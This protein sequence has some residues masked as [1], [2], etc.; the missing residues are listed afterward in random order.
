MSSSTLCRFIRAS[1]P[2]FYIKTMARK[3]GEQSVQL[4]CHCKV[5]ENFSNELWARCI[6]CFPNLIEEVRCNAK[7]ADVNM[8]RSNVDDIWRMVG[9]LKRKMSAYYI[10]A[11][12]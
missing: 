7:C 3:K 5:Q 8:R 9:A 12:E 11:M 4:V 6:K 2:S 1:D 10:V